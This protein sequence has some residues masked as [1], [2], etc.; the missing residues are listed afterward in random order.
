MSTIVIEIFDK[1]KQDNI[2]GSRET[3]IVSELLA[4]RADLVARELK[5]QFPA[6]K[7]FSVREKNNDISLVYGAPVD[8][9]E[10]IAK[11]LQALLVN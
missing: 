1:L 8:R 2:I 3:N 5:M 4:N 11:A 6:V 9:V 10:E 7:I